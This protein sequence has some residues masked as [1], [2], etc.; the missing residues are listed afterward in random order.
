[1]QTLVFLPDARGSIV[2]SRLGM[3][4]RTLKRRLKD[5]GE[6]LQAFR[7]EVRA[8][9]ACQPL[10]YTEKP[11]GEIATILGYADA[12]AFARAFRR[13]RGVGPANWRS[14]EPE[15]SARIRARR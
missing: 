12:S 1:M 5:E 15:A 14:R 8:E 3:S 9:A 6:S 10:Q 2:A 4:L 13:W 11:A 7:D